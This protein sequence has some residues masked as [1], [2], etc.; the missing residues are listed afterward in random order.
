MA[1]ALAALQFAFLSPAA[2]KK[3][4]Y[5]VSFSSKFCLIYMTPTSFSI[6]FHLKLAESHAWYFKFVLD[7]ID[8]SLSIM[9]VY[10]FLKKLRGIVHQFFS[11]SGRRNG[12]QF[13]GCVNASNPRNAQGVFLLSIL[14]L[15]VNLVSEMTLCVSGGF[16]P[17]LRS[18]LELATNSELY[19]L[20]QILFGPRLFCL[21][22][23]HCLVAF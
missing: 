3:I 5:P 10:S 11:S 12:V 20:E 4:A 6:K 9:Y 14:A 13:V 15:F 7:T 1:T 2:S 23:L 22:L 18:V 16:D 17:D 19:E 8:Y 21:P